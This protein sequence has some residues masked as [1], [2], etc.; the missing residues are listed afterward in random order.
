M[1]LQRIYKVLSV[2]LVT[3]ILFFTVGVSVYRHYCACTSKAIVSVFV[4]S[5][6]DNDHG[7]SCCASSSGQEHKCC[8]TD[9]SDTN[10]SHNSCDITGACKTETSIFQIESEYQISQEKLQKADF[11]TEVLIAFDDISTYEKPVFISHSFY[12]DTSPPRIGREF[13]TSVHQL[14]LDIP[15]C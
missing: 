9:T 4:E 14:K 15:V 2:F 13:L 3:L 8:S 12:T 1:R 6:C 11:T 5:V 7:R 10:G